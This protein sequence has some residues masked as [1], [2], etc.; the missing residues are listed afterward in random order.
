MTDKQAMVDPCTA[1]PSINPCG[2]L[3][4]LIAE[5]TW[6][7]IDWKAHGYKLDIQLIREKKS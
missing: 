5:S 1:Q 7:E 2:P 3:P 6:T 4:V